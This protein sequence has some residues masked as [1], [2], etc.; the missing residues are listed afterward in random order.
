M[1]HMLLITDSYVT[2]LVGLSV[3]MH[4]INI[5][6]YF[7]YLYDDVWC[8]L[9]LQV[10]SDPGASPRDTARKVSALEQNMG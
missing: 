6:V 7:L 2:H 8:F 5:S 9:S 1:T 3:I 10:N 4:V